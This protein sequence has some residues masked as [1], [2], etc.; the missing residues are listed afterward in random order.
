VIQIAAVCLTHCNNMVIFV[1]AKQSTI[2]RMIS[3][4]TRQCLRRGGTAVECAAIR[5]VTKLPTR[6]RRNPKQPHNGITHTQRLAV[7]HS[8]LTRARRDLPNE[9]RRATK[10]LRRGHKKHKTGA[11]DSAKH[12]GR[13]RLRNML[14]AAAPPTTAC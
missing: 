9:R 14:P 10:K 5:V 8:R 2:H 3:D 11:H 7:D 1:V 13:Q 6:W 12:P 4:Q